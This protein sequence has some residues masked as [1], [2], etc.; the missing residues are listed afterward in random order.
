MVSQSYMTKVHNDITEKER[1]LMYYKI[2]ENDGF[3]QVNFSFLHSL[4]L[5]FGHKLLIFQK[6]ILLLLKKIY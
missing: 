2:A 1:K 5:V 3:D 6:T 4:S